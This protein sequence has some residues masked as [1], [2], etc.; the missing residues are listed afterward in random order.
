MII[1]KPRSLASALL[2]AALPMGFALAGGAGG[3]G[4]AALGGGLGAAGM[5]STGVGGG[6]PAGAVEG[7]PRPALWG[8]D[9]RDRATRPATERLERATQAEMLAAPSEVAPMLH[10]G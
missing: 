4:G 5:G 2:I 6:A 7:G 1:C 10:R 9:R 3:R 8:A